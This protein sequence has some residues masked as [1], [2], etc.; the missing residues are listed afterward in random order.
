MDFLG[1]EL[2]NPAPFGEEG[3]GLVFMAGG[4]G[5]AGA[6]FGG[7][8]VSD[9]RFGRAF[10]QFFADGDRNIWIQGFKN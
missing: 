5:L 1:E 7:T 6:V 9:G 4:R 8:A 10:D 2:E 3:H